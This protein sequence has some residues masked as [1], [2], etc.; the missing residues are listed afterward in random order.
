L[1]NPKSYY[2]RLDDEPRKRQ[3]GELILLE[4]PFLVVAD[5]MEP[6]PDLELRCTRSSTPLFTTPVSS[7]AV[8]DHLRLYLSRISAPRVTMHGVFLDILGMGVL[9]MGES[10][11][12]KSEL[13]PGTD[14]ARPWPRGRRRG[15]F[16]AAGP[17][18]IEGRCPPLLQNLLE[19]RGLGLL[20]IKTI[21]GETAV[22]RKMKLKLVVQLVR[23]N[24][25]EFERLPLDSQYLDVLGLPD[26]HGEDPGGSRSKSRRAGRSRRPQH[27][28]APARHRHPARLHGPS[29]GSDAGRRGFAQPGSAALIAPIPA[30]FETPA[31]T[32]A[33]LTRAGG[34]RQRALGA[35]RCVL[36]WASSPVRYRQP[37]CCILKAASGHDVFPQP[38]ESMKKLIAM[39]VLVTP[40]FATGAFAQAPRLRPLKNLARR[41]SRKRC[42]PAEAEQGQEG[43]RLQEKHER[44]PVG[45]RGSRR[46]SRTDPAGKDV[47]VREGKQGQEG[48]RLQEVHERLP[49]KA[50]CLIARS[51]SSRGND[52]ESA[53]IRHFCFQGRLS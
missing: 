49:V 26:P 10:G 28:T 17:D 8:I 39:C 38:G 18:F 33:Q 47:G 5:G 7:A 45:Q 23:R 3:M 9:I 2:Q 16:R 52:G 32:R 50:S 25:G 22:R 36:Q 11:L 37:P 21:F 42:R 41:R 24:D 14:L 20:D 29:A 30:V 46:A 48:R 51:G 19:V 44:L 35:R 53:T 13:G 6:P 34:P 27:D 12:G 15:G 4:P 31:S 1:A 43:R 40:L